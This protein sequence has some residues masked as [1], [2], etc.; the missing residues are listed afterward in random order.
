MIS[1]AR[2]SSSGFFV[3]CCATGVFEAPDLVDSGDAVAD[4]GS[5]TLSL[6]LFDELAALAFDC[7]S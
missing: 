7:S 1:E 6:A 3:F 4:F 2:D 5:T